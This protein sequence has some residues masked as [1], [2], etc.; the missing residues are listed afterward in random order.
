M[1]LERLTLGRRP[2]DPCRR[3]QLRRRAAARRPSPPT[4]GIR[5][6]RPRERVL[7][8]RQSTL[9]DDGDETQT[10]FGFCVGREPDRPRPRRGG[11]ATP[12]IGPPGC[13]A[14]PSRPASG[15]PSCSTRSSRPSSSA[16][17]ASTLNG[18]AVVKGR[19][20]FA[21]PPRRAGRRRRSSR[22]STTPPT[23]GAY[24]ATDVDGEGLAARRNV[25]IDDGVLQQ[26]VHNSLHGPAGRHGV[27]R[28]R[29]A[30]R[31]RGHA[32]RRLPR[33]AARARAPATRPS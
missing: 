29:R 32:R 26:F 10:G 11:R 22:S 18:E 24:T 9:A 33:A 27:D 19:S 3:R 30:R 25:L 21:R 20:L 28:Q 13:S 31:V 4:T 8:Q 6:V 12:S 17:S 1:E 14:P 15:S 5:A 2:A 7:R 16:S 23:R